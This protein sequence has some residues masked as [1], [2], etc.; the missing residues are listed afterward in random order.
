[1]NIKYRAKD[2]LNLPT[3]TAM[4]ISLPAWVNLLWKNKFAIDVEYWPKALFI[5]ATALL[6]MP[7]QLYERIRFNKKIKNTNVLPPVFILGHP[8]SGTTWLQYLLSKDPTFAFCNTADGLMP[9][10]FL[11]AGNI[12]EKILNAAMPATRPQDNV[13]AGVML[14]IEE[15]FAMGNMSNTSWV[16][17]LYFP[18]NIYKWFDEYVTF[19]GSE[20]SRKQWKSHFDFLL[21]KLTHKYGE[22]SLLLKSPA[23]TGRLKELLE[24]Y[25]NAKFIHIHRNP[26][27]VYLSNERLYEKILPIIG[28]QKVGNTFIEEHILYAYEE[29]YKK[30]LADRELI[31][32]SQLIEISYEA[33]A[34]AP[35]DFIKKIY[36]HLGLTSLDTA[37]PFFEEELN[38]STN[39][40]RNSYSKIDEALKEKIIS[41]W[42]FAFNAFGY[43][44]R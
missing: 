18:R 17:G 7:V 32:K 8:R 20:E 1:M 6:N 35:L 33:F 10:I 29:M 9:N 28:F 37:L 21:K 43:P 5:T 38:G 27:S 25:P 15:E 24:L 34:H 4:G 40:E 12:S 22:K 11:S 3:H 30:Y 39:Y 31:P 2:F 41:R 42:K 16:H 19:K 13:K 36:E 26:F 44:M 23:N 14:P